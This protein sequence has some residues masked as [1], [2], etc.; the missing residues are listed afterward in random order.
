MSE[1]KKSESRGDFLSS[2]DKRKYDI[3]FSMTYENFIKSMEYYGYQ[4]GG[5]ESE[6]FGDR[7]TIFYHQEFGI[8]FY[9]YFDFRGLKKIVFAGEVTHPDPDEMTEEYKE[10]YKKVTL[11]MTWMGSH[12]QVKNEWH[13]QFE[14]KYVRTDFAM[15]EIDG[16]LSNIDNIFTKL[17]CVQKW[18]KGYFLNE[19][20]LF[21]LTPTEDYYYPV[22]E[23]EERV[24][25]KIKKCNSDVKKIINS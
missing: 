5:Y 11:G 12:F 16:M 19:S 21:F 20:N 23:Q 6:K 9:A 22:N 24:R 10:C 13:Y 17:S 4:R 1:T 8:V 15:N 3:F 2:N 7:E 14:K 25:E 18:T